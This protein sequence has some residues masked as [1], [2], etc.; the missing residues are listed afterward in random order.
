MGERREIAGVRKSGEEFPAEAA[1]SQVHQG[2]DVVFTVVLRDVT[3]RKRFEQRQQFLAE[4][5]EKLA[6]SFGSSETLTQVA[7]LAVPRIA[8]GCILENRIGNGFLAGAAAHVDP[9]IE[10]ILDE[11]GAGRSA[12]PAAR[13]I[14]STRFC[15]KPSPVLL[16]SERCVPPPRGERQFRLPEG[17]EGDESQIRA[18]PSARRA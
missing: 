15:A 7:R 1:I 11:I 10:E 5:G 14:R 8:D 3:V 2:D 4:A 13:V 12:H 17:G 18:F 6:S 16:Q 9:A